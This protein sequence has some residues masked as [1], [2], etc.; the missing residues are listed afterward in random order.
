VQPSKIG[1]VIQLNQNIFY[2]FNH[3]IVMSYSL[4]SLNTLNGG[5]ASTSLD[6]F[7]SLNP[8]QGDN[9]LT[10]SVI[11]PQNVYSSNSCIPALTFDFNNPVVSSST[12][13]PF[14]YEA[15]AAMNMA[16]AALL[17]SNLRRIPAILTASNAFE[18]Q[19][20]PECDTTLTM[21]TTPASLAAMVTGHPI[22]PL[23][24]T[25]LISPSAAMP[26]IACP[27]PDGGGT[28]KVS[29]FMINLKNNNTTTKW[30]SL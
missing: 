9:L 30:A 12:P 23:Q 27:T 7:L 11:P 6:S 16:A 4:L 19:R 8:L 14:L 18:F 26:Y 13:I 15:N 20:A 2:S 10:N 24:T 17:N 28:K 29:Y 5:N 25:S 22:G 1:F 21:R 3:Q